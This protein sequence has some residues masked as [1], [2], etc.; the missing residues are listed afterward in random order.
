MDT[1]SALYM[2]FSPRSNWMI[3]GTTLND[4]A[5]HRFLTDRL[6]WDC[7]RNLFGWK[8]RHPTYQLGEHTFST[9]LANACYP[10]MEMLDN[11][12]PSNQY[13]VVMKETQ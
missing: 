13:I 8:D 4:P 2:R 12:P 9:D 5:K 3:Q 10:S 11:Q 7:E 1:I 6:K